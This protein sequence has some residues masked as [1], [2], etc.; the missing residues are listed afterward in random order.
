MDLESISQETLEAVKKAQTAGVLSSTGIFGY[1]LA[2]YVQLIPVNT[3]YRNIVSRV[4]ASQGAKFAIWR[5]LLNVNSTQPSPFVAPDFAG[6]IAN[7][8]EQ[9]MQAQFAVVAMGGTVTQDAVDFA[10]SY[11]DARALA[12]VNVLNQ[13]MIGEDKGLLMGQRS[14]LATPGTPTV[15]PA[16]T[17]GT[18]PASTA[19]NVKV[20]ARTGGNYF[21][22]GSTVASAQGTATT[23]S[24]T[25][26]NS[27]VLSVAAVKGAVA[28]DWYVAGFYVTTTTVNTTLITAIPTANA[29][30]V[31]NLP[32]LFTTAPTA[33]PTVDASANAASLDGLYATLACDYSAAGALVTP[34]TGTASGAAYTS[35]NGATLTAS[36]PGIVEIDAMLLSIYNNVRLSPD[37]LMM[38]AQEATDIATK[39]IGNGSVVNFLQQPD[40]PTHGNITAGGFVG[41]YI[42]KAAGGVPVKIEVHPHLVQGRIIARTDSL[43]FPG[44]NVGAT[45]RVETLRDYSDFSYGAARVAATAGGGPREDFEVRSVEAFENFAP[46]AMGLIENIL[47]G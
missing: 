26:T 19:V 31:P 8:D 25:A 40:L 42:N 33:V 18:I 29:A 1:N 28:Y 39:I 21:W 9:D 30:T 7:I 45:C 23:G 6:G 34:G 17:G 41:T 3:T 36:G 44:S 35:L 14:A 12:T 32:D 4:P 43:P 47:A 38:N 11:A 13:T 20:A 24:G 27:A 22:G 10:K 16:A 37:A 46:V 15:T 5:A 2:D